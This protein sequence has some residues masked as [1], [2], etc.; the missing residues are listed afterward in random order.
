MWAKNAR[1]RLRPQLL[2]RFPRRTF[3]FFVY[4][5]NFIDQFFF[6]KKFAEARS[7]QQDNLVIRI[8][9]PDLSD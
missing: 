6:Q 7:A 2:Q 5:K 9:F 8:E 4:F 1:P 3:I